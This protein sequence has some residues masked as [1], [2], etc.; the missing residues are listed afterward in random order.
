M[1]KRLLPINLK[2][3]KRLKKLLKETTNSAETKRI[4]AMIVYL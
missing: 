4:N 1:A 2:E 3:V